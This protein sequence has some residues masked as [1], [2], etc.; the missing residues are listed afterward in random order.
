MNASIFSNENINEVL[1]HYKTEDN[2]WNSSHFYPNP[3]VGSMQVEESDR[4]SLTIENSEVGQTYWYITAGS[5]GLVGRYPK[6]GY[7]HYAVVGIPNS[8]IWNANYSI[9]LLYTSPSPRD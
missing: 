7:E 9:C 4:W 6:Y 2:D 5:S 1:F 8:R 3:I